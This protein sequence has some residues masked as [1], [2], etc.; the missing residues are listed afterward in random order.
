M[1]NHKIANLESYVIVVYFYNRGVQK[2]RTRDP[3]GC[4]IRARRNILIVSYH[5][6]ISLFYFN[7][8]LSLIYTVN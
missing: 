4:A 6:V 8:S 7:I 5:D 3:E 1:F 2:G